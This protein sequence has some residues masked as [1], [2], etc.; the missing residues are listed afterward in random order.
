MDY[1]KLDPMNHSYQLN[2][3]STD[4]LH[5]KMQSTCTA[6]SVSH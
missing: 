1:I 2:I 5:F 6:V 4:G 3:N